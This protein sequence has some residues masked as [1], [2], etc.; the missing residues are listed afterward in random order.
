[1][2]PNERS[3]R[4]LG[5]RDYLRRLS[6]SIP[7]SVCYLRTKASRLS[8]EAS[9]CNQA[10]T[11]KTRPKAPPDGSDPIRGH[12]VQDQVLAI[13]ND[14]VPHQVLSPL[15][16]R[17]TQLQFD[18]LMGAFLHFERRAIGFLRLQKIG[19]APDAVFQILPCI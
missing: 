6:H 15:I 19:V 12:G 17:R 16:T 5:E 3:A 7:S 18:L 2:Q 10:I 1:M 14:L 8:N 11:Q 4:I 13:A 9:F